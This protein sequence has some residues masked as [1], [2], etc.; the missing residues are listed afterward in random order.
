MDLHN[1]LLEHR[2]LMAELIAKKSDGGNR[3]G[4]VLDQEGINHL[5]QKIFVALSAK[6]ALKDQVVLR[7][8]KVVGHDDQ[9]VEQLTYFRPLR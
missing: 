8:Q 4:K 3:G 5:D 9:F 7:T 2:G 1:T 6:N